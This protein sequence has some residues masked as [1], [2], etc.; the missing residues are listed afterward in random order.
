VV[1][2]NYHYVLKPKLDIPASEYDTLCPLPDGTFEGA[3]TIITHL[4]KGVINL[5]T[6]KA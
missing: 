6:V 3:E 2:E 4:I 5:Y 1:G